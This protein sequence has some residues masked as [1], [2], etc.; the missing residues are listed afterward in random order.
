MA[1]QTTNIVFINP[2]EQVSPA[3]LAGMLNRNVSQIYQW[4]QTGRLPDVKNGVFSYRQCLDHLVTSLLRMEEAKALKDKARFDGE[5]LHPLVEEKLKQNIKTERAR[6]ADLW[7]KIAI[8]RG[9][10]VS[11]EKKLDLVEGF[12]LSIRDTLLSIANNNPALQ[13]QI[14]NAMEELYQAGKVL[15]EEADIDA[16]EFI[17]TMLAVEV[18]I[19]DKE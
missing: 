8:K 3:I 9:E 10:Y 18:E 2:D 12:I 5:G 6:E 1:E 19:E 11:F 14:D 15:V 16:N 4:G 7:Q 17:D 13:G